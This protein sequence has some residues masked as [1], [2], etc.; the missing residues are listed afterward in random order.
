MDAWEFWG[1]GCEPVIPWPVLPAGVR[2]PP[3]G[4]CG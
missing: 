1:A 3:G 4:Q 2:R